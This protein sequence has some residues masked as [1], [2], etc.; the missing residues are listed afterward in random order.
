MKKKNIIAILVI[1]A[2]IT[3]IIVIL[4]GNK[5]VIN[6]HNQIEDRSQV[7]IAVNVSPVVLKKI[8]KDVVRPAVVLPNE[9][10]LIAASMP[11]K[12]EQ[13]NIK[14]G[15]HVRRGQTIGKIDTKVNDVQ[16]EN[17]KLAVEKAKT[18]FD[19]N[20]DLYKGKALSEKQYLDSKYGYESQKIKL[21]QLKEQISES[22]IKSPLNGIITQKNNV[23]GEFVGAGTAI[24]SVVDINTLKID[25]YVN[26]NEVLF[27]QLNQSA[28]IYSSVAPD[29]SLVGKVT[30]I[31]PN[32]DKNF[33]Y[34]VEVQV[35]NKGN[36]RILRP[37]NYVNVHFHP[38]EERKTL[39]IPKNA[40]VN[41][42][43]DAYVYVENG[44]RAEKR[45]I[46]V[47]QENGAYIEVLK[48][49]KQG[50]KV[51]VDGQI[52]IVDNS[53]IDTKNKK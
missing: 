4:V 2:I 12:L 20:S 32:A 23:A 7:A 21:D 25:V 36:K 31:S 47:G 41:G 9:T 45:I 42:V 18:D 46:K 34:K 28:K 29:T 53:L 49:L 3:V 40:L 39:Q 52:N 6:K 51:I 14:L 13:L 15:D 5:K 27:I 8:D 19:R 33:N 22:Y 38:T 50:E 48:G 17:L 30:Y 35:K 26:E 1:A 44:D 43:K 10:A 24:A 37:G 16:L 11:G